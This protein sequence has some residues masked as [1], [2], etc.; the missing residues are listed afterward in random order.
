MS[1]STLPITDG[2]DA[3]RVIHVSKDETGTVAHAA[4]ELSTWIQK[5][6]GAKLPIVGDIDLS[7]CV[8]IAPPSYKLH[9]RGNQ[10]DLHD[11]GFTLHADGDHLQIVGGS[12]VG[13][14]CG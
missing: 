2:G 10:A 3:C 11:Q 6:S 13:T 1:K 9:P 4:E 7:H 8:A 14:H 5:I 12:P